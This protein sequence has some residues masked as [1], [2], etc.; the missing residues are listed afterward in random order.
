M[1]V[2]GAR[3]VTHDVQGIN[4][5]KIT[6]R[7]TDDMKP[8]VRNR[9]RQRDFIETWSGINRPYGCELNSAG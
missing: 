5:Y 4:L 3:R 6:A 1:K 8:M 2:E 9:N 7:T